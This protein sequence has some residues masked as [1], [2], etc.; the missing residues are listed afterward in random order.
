MMFVQAPAVSAPVRRPG[1]SGRFAKLSCLLAGLLLALTAALATAVF[2]IGSLPALLGYR[3][4]VVTSGSMAP[5]IRV[6]DA[7]AIGKVVPKTIRAGDVITFATVGG[8]GMVTHRVVA[9]K[10][11]EG[12]AYFQTKGDANESLDPNLASAQAVYGKMA[13]RVPAGGYL[14]SYAA[15]AWGKWLLVGGPL[16]ILLVQEVVS[17]LRARRPRFHLAGGPAVREAIPHEVL[18]PG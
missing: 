10:E 8:K 13:W 11:I 12:V 4:M 15:T 5:T 17:L 16:F 18:L 6:G 7:V 1:L 9:I 3:T 2:V 14:L